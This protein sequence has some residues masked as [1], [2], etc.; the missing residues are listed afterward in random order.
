MRD[1]LLAF[2]VVTLSVLVVGVVVAFICWLAVKIDGG[3]Q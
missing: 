3:G 2:G 1:F